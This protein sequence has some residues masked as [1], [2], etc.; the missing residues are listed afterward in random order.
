MSALDRRY[1][2]PPYASDA[3]NTTYE[4]GSLDIRPGFR[5]I[6]GTQRYKTDAMDALKMFDFA[7]GIVDDADYTTYL[8]VE[9][10]GSSTSNLGRLMLVDTTT[11]ARTKVLRNK[12]TNSRNRIHLGGATGGTYTLTVTTS[13]GTAA[14]TGALNW[15]DAFGVVDAAVGGL[16]NIG[17]AGNVTTIA[18]TGGFQF[19]WD[20]TAL[21]ATNITVTLNSSLT[22]TTD[23]PV[24]RQVR[25]AKTESE[26]WLLATPVGGAGNFDFTFYGQTVN[27]SPA[28]LT[29]AQLRDTFL[30]SLSNVF[31]GDVEC[32]SYPGGFL[33][34]WQGRYLGDNLSSVGVIT[35]DTTS[36]TSITVITDGY[37][38]TYSSDGTSAVPVLPDSYTHMLTVDSVVYGF[39]YSAGDEVPQTSEQTPLWTMDLGDPYSFAAVKP[40]VSPD[41]SGDKAT[42]QYRRQPGSATLGYKLWNWASLEAGDGVEDGVIFTTALTNADN[43]SADITVADQGLGTLLVTLAGLTASNQNYQ[44]SDCHAFR[45]TR[46]A[47]T[48]VFDLSSVQVYMKDTAGTR[49]DMDTRVLPISSSAETNLEYCVFCRFPPGKTRTNWTTTKHFGIEV[50]VTA[51]TGTLTLSPVKIGGM[52]GLYV[53]NKDWQLG[54]AWKR[55]DT[56]LVSGIGGAITLPWQD[57]RGDLA[58][59]SNAPGFTELWMGVIP[60]LTLQGSDETA[61]DLTDIV[62]RQEIALGDRSGDKAWSQWRK[63]DE[64]TEASPT[65]YYFQTESATFGQK[66]AFT[67]GVFEYDDI[68]NAAVIHGSVLWMFRRNHRLCIR[69]SAVGD[70]LNLVK[71]DNTDLDILDPNEGANFT[72]SDQYNDQA[73]MALPIPN[74][75][76]IGALGGIFVQNGSVPLQM[77]P[78]YRLP[79]SMGVCGPDAIKLWHDQF[80]NPAI[81]YVT[82]KADMVNMVP[83]LA[84]G[85]PQDKAYRPGELSID[86]RG[87]VQD[88]LTQGSL[89]I[90]TD[91]M[92]VE[93]D[94][95]GDS[96]LIV[97]VD[98][99]IV[100]KRKSLM[101]GKRPWEKHRY[102]M[103]PTGSSWLKAHF[104]EDVGYRL[105]RIDGSLDEIWFDSSDNFSEIVPTWITA[106]TLSAASDYLQFTTDPVWPIGSGVVVRKSGNGLVMGTTYYAYPLGVS[107]RYSLYNSYANAVAGG[108]TGKMDITG[109]TVDFGAIS[110]GR[111]NLQTLDAG[112]FD[113]Y[114]ESGD[115]DDGDWWQL[116]EVAVDRVNLDDRPVV[117]IYGDRMD[118]GGTRTDEGGTLS[119]PVSMTCAFGKR[120][121]YPPKWLRSQTMR[122][123]VELPENSSRVQAMDCY[124]VPAQKI[125]NS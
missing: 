40:P 125:N 20:G 65:N 11:G 27:I 78:V 18:S 89:S 15:N 8:T 53:P 1:V 57:L 117:K 51:G 32:L 68:V 43:V 59:A 37:E 67:Q 47:T 7:Q 48:L 14:T 84:V 115:H 92:L 114:W 25:A 3:L 31:D 22:G 90:N 54:Y 58:F 85:D 19:T 113:A 96:L 39:N 56:G 36:G 76:V 99:A 9:R 108:S 122:Y 75:A 66:P 44:Y 100:M 33:I 38:S 87:H 104:K 110:E 23:T 4:D 80:D 34:Y 93:V 73:V 112:G 17:G 13:D 109:S 30:E 120:S 64:V 82:P 16:A 123:R 72:L 97:Y 28:A 71:L 118:R 77:S 10:Y 107:N 42:V 24:G 62:V 81:V 74:G 2:Q 79:G 111:D 6:V 103:G 45:I 21:A 121:I 106:L 91:R 102:Y 124:R 35:N 63:V 49:V 46:S 52:P 61:V 105:M 41:D 101:D 29:G 55:S 94:P 98:R 70:P 119:T 50:N 12:S 83:I 95:R 88:F 26:V 86:L 60:Y 69:Y 116:N 5:Q